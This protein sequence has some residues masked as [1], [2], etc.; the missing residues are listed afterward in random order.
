MVGLVAWQV[1]SYFITVNFDRLSKC[2]SLEN[3]ISRIIENKFEGCFFLFL[4][5][6]G[7]SNP[8]GPYLNPSPKLPLLKLTRPKLSMNFDIL[9]ILT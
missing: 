1:S 6:V 5:H 3:S 4:A 7:D 8:L 9:N 2:T